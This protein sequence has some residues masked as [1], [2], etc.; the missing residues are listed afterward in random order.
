MP[1]SPTPTDLLESLQFLT[2]EERAELDRLLL[3][4]PVPLWIP[5]PKNL[6]QCEAYKSRA[7]IIGIG[8]SAGGGK[9]DA[10]IGKAVTQHKKSLILRREYKQVRALWD[11]LHEI[12]G[13]KGNPNESLHLWRNLPGGRSIEF[14]GCEHLGDEEAFQGRPHDFVYFDEAQY[15][16]ESQVRFLLTWLRHPDPK[17]SCQAM[18]GFNPPRSAEGRW[19]IKFFAPWLDK[20]YP[21]RAAPGELRWFASLGPKGKK[22]EKEV[23]GP[24]PITDIDGEVIYPRSR[25]F[26]PARV[27]DNPYWEGTDYKSNLQALPEPWRSQALYGDMDAGATDDD[28]QVIPTE[29][30]EAA[31]ARWDA[32]TDPGRLSVVG[33]DPARGGADRTV[34]A[35]RY[36]NWFGRLIEYP[37]QSTPDGQRVFGLLAPLL[38]QGGSAN[39]DVIGI[40][41]AVYDVGT[42]AGA[43]VNAINVS[44]GT[45]ER[46]RSGN[47]GFANQRSWMYWRVR[48]LLDP[49]RPLDPG[50]EP[51]ALPPDEQLKAELA[52]HRYE[53]VARGIRVRPKD[54]VKDILGHSPDKAEAVALACIIPSGQFDADAYLEALKMPGATVS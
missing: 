52:A 23:P 7:H 5:N 10:G 53:P 46:D 13:G 8:G 47:F 9:S 36:G 2:P 30:I 27:D 26:I 42:L 51:V 49:A 1:D 43:A 45:E 33:V 50:E 14:G 34:F 20:G 40:G 18:L 19:L 22:V 3:T 21:N 32:K 25:T 28:W 39:I 54:E 17:Q 4:R 48:E 31:M 44:E 12:A 15:F 6:P 37:G 38:A 16:L 35:P 11:R 24:D 29:W 41:S